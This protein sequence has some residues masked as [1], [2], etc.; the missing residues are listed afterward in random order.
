MNDGNLKNNRREC[1]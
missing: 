1:Y